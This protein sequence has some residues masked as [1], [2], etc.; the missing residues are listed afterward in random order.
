MF[1]PVVYHLVSGTF[2]FVFF[3]DLGISG[4]HGLK[5]HNTITHKKSLKLT[6]SHIALI[7][8]L[9]NG[10]PIDQLAFRKFFSPIS[11]M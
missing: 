6:R 8:C 9:P 4:S 1:C 5:K 2:S 7:N 11:R 10:I 3:L